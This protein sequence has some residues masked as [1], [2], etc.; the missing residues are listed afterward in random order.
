MYRSRL[1]VPRVRMAFLLLFVLLLFLPPLCAG[2]APL[3]LPSPFSAQ[4]GSMPVGQPMQFDT[5]GEA[6]LVE[7]INQSRAAEGL[8]ALTVDARLQQAARKHT[9]LM[10]E[11]SQLSHQFDGEAAMQPRFIAEGLPS[12]REGENVA[13]NRTVPG[14]HA[15]LMQSPLHRHNILGPDYNVVGVGILHSEGNVYVTEDFARR[16]PEY[17]EP[18]AEAAVEAAINLRAKSQGLAQPQRKPQLQLRHMACSMA[19]TDTLD[20]EGPAELP[21]VHGVMIWTAGDPGKIPDRIAKQ[22]S[23]AMP[24][25]Y[26]LGACFAPSVSHPG[27]VY[28]IVIVTY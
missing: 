10:V 19:L 27:G 16:L 21:G 8:P 23:Q 12:D 28:W 24:S 15:A 20:N 3:A 2:K 13:L 9:A 7:L 4:A 22:L 1:L 17:S 18:Q 11:R 26:S 14:A 6:Q 25:G 5:A